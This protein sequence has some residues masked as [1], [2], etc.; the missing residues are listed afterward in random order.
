M[1]TIAGRMLQMYILQHWLRNFTLLT[2][3]PPV[4]Y[5]KLTS[6]TLLSDH[7]W[8]IAPGRRSLEGG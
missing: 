6:T 8:T 1:S 4:M 5:A 3:V 2:L 7:L